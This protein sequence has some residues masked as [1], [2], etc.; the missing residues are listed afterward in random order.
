MRRSFLTGTWEIPASPASDGGT[1][2]PAKAASPTAGM[3]DV[4]KSDECVVPRKH[5]NNDAVGS[6]EDAEGR[7]STER[8]AQEDAAPRTQSRENASIGLAGV[9]E[10]A[11]RSKKTRF[12]ALLHHV[13]VD[14]LRDSFLALKRRA[15]PGVDGETWQQ[16][17]ENLEARIVRLHEAVHRG[18]YRALPS[19][20]VY[21]PKPDGSLRPL[22]IAALEDKIV[23]QAVVTVLNAVYEADFLGFSY[24]FRP[25]RSQHDCLDAL[26]MG[27]WT[28]KVNWVLDADIRGFFDTIDH[29]WMVRFLEHRIGDRRIVRLIQK[30]L[31]AG[32]IEDGVR[33]P[34]PVGTPQGAVISPLLANIYLH[35]AFDLWA[36]Q[37]R[38]KYAHGQVITVRYADD[39]VLGF[40]HLYDA[41]RF[42]Y[43]FAKRLQQFGLSL[44]PEKTRLIRFGR[45]AAAACRKAG[46]KRPATFDFLGFTHICGQSRVGEFVVRR[47][48]SKKRMRARL[49]AI[50][51]TLTRIMHRPIA[52][53]GR[54]IR[55][56]VQGYF[57]YHAIRGNSSRLTGFRKAVARLW[58]QALRRRSQRRRLNWA[59]FG[60]YADHWIP[61][62]RILHPPP[63]VRFDAKYSR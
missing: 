41:K 14:L 6:A 27:I 52:E 40:Q 60:H 29:G 7:R 24:G 10:A 53:Q 62:P 11:R 33:K 9:R 54:W 22:G 23:Q 43:A 59:R 39:L 15:A 19:K 50:K 13:T 47:L 26:W 45:F 35:Y 63:A 32:V 30:W 57:N 34:T 5:P 46:L 3:H 12:T 37:W 20:R 36:Q 48:S 2:R 42:M 58:L 44:H 51:A 8:N 38:S 61:S 28:T 49:A 25:G 56:V 21:I 18:S 55:R 31:R 17:E 16:Y 1:G 4:G